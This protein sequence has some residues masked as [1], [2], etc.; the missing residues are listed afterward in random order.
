[1][2]SSV[3]RYIPLVESYARKIR[4]GQLPPGARM[5]SVRSLTRLHRIALATAHRVYAELEESGLIVGEVGRGTFVRDLSIQR[6]AALRQRKAAMGTVD[7]SFNYPTVP[8]QDEL[9]RESLRRLAGRGDIDAM[10][11]LPPQGGGSYERETAARH[12]RNRGLKLPGAQVLLV[13][14]AQHGLAIALQAFLHPGDVVAV[15]AL[16]YPGFRSLALAHR[17]DPCPVR[18]VDG[19]TDLDALASLCR[20]RRIKAVYTMPTLHNPLG[21]VMPIDKRRQLMAIAERHDLLII[22]DGAYAFLG[23]PAPPPLMTLAPHRTV[24]VSGLSKSVASGLR[25]GMVAAPLALIPALEDAIRLTTW[26]APALSVALACDWIQD[27]TVDN[28]EESKRADARERQRIARIALKGLDP[29]GHRTSYFLWLDLPAG[30][31]AEVVASDLLRRGVLVAT[32]EAFAPAS[33]A[34]QGMRLA[35]GSVPMDVLKS[36]LHVVRDTVEARA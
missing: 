19:M 25:V 14:G 22:E 2:P 3:S 20:R 21:S 28:L 30:V 13:N 23:E 35:I 7:L 9:L 32:G 17:V 4:E 18:Q 6:P 24:Y 16:T 10:L 12:L 36:A 5:P 27:G 33:Y 1:M 11:H 31:R 26:S 29:V 34:R 15:D 8:G